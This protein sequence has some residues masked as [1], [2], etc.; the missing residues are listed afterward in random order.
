MDRYVSN[1]TGPT[2]FE[3]SVDVLSGDGTIIQ[4]WEY[5]KCNVNDY[6]T[7]VNSDKED[8]RFSDI[9]DMEI[10]EIFVFACHGFNLRS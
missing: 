10:R 1:P 6:S 7:F 5:R 3:V 2:R 9:D 8:Y 4:T